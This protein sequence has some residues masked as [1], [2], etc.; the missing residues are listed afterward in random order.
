MNTRSLS[1]GLP[2]LGR[3][4]LPLAVAV[5]AAT[6]FVAPPAHAVKQTGGE[7]NTMY[8]GLGAKGYD[9]VSYFT[10][11]KPT[12]G[13]AQHESVYGG[14]TW[15]FANEKNLKL[16]AANP[17]KYAPQY[18]G[19]CSW[20]VAN[21]RLFDVDPVNGWTIVDGKLYLNFNADL[22]NTFAKE[23]TK[24]IPMAEKNWPTLDR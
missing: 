2:Y 8:A 23:A 20:G 6:G 21:G 24:F 10:T 14:V 3:A 16:F 17:E 18:G 4:L 12:V 11:G 5:V 15:R 1:K 22:N 9:V 19:F 7:Y 13:S